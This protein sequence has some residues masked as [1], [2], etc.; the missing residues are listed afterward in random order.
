M[1]TRPGQASPPCVGN[2]A[3]YDAVLFDADNTSPTE[4]T[5][6]VHRA[7]A[8]CRTCLSPCEQK[9]TVD[10]RP[11]ELVLLDPDW[12]PPQREGTPEPE[13]RVQTRRRRTS[14]TDGDY[15]PTSQRVTV[16]AEMCADQAAA[17]RSIT[18]I[19]ADLCVSED[20]VVRLI[21]VARKARG[22]AA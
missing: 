10:S 17:G 1:I 6:A 12:L 11:A 4:R 16:W 7:A 8:L 14:R 9:V 21:A 18:D 5:Q 3:L 15:V 22:W 19:A 20:T 2:A 13:P